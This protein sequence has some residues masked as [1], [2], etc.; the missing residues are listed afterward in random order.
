MIDFHEA[1]TADQVH[2]PRSDVAAAH[3]ILKMILVCEALPS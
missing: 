3:P 1:H 2:Y